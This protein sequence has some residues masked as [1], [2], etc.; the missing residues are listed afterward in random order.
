MITLCAPVSLKLTLFSEAGALQVSQ[1]AE[2]IPKLAAYVNE[3]KIA[4]LELIGETERLAVLDALEQGG[5]FYHLH[6]GKVPVQS[7]PLL[8]DLRERAHFGSLVL[9]LLP[10][11]EKLSSEEDERLASLRDFADKALAVGLET[12]ASVNLTSWV[13]H[14]LSELVAE[15]QDLGINHVFCYR[16]SA[17]S[18]RQA[19]ASELA[20]ALQVLLSLRRQG[21]SISLGNCVPNCFVNTDS[22]GCLGGITSAVV[23]ALGN[24]Y[25]CGGSS[26]SAGNLLENELTEIWRSEVMEKWREALPEEC[27]HCAKA[28]LCPGG[29]RAIASRGEAKCDPLIRRAFS[30]DAEELHEVVLEEDLCPVPCY[31]VRAEEFGWTLMRGERVIPVSF[32]AQEILRLFDGEHTLAQIERQ[33]GTAALSFVYSLYVRGFVEFSEAKS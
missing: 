32:Q 33:C 30:E 28:E 17:V 9:N 19:E 29:C 18:G 4:G 25:P 3:F 20:Q 21:I 2:L 8:S 10:S 6:I 12:N 11:D 7:L 13:C 31:A 5:K 14:H 15:A 1:W 22:P 16:C 24:V 26:E 27:A 23:D